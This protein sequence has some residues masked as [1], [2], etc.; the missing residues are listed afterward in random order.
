[1]ASF[2]LEHP[3]QLGAD[4][5]EIAAALTQ[6]NASTQTVV[7]R[8][9]MRL[10]ATRATVPRDDWLTFCRQAIVSHQLHCLLTQDP[11]T[12]RSFAKPRGYPGDA[13]MLDYIYR[14]ETADNATA[15]GRDVLT[16]LVKSELS[17]A[18]RHRLGIMA[19][20]IDDV[21]LS[22]NAPRVL[23]LGAGHLREGRLSKSISSGVRP[24]T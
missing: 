20:A 8:L 19:A 11:F 10:D 21:A 15:L 12:K 23:A 18:V 2:P 1:M 24:I 16:V 17:E 6:Q 13:A 4:L 7:E 9:L 3:A 14:F 22:H 5:D